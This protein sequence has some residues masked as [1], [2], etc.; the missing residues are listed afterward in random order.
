MQ[1]AQREALA[2]LRLTWAPTADDLWRPQSATHVPGFNE[3]AIEDVIDAVG[4]A[5]RDP[6]SSPLGVVVQGRAGSGKTHLLGQVRER[7]QAS[8]GYFLL[9]ELLDAATFWESV[10]GGIIDSLG[11]PGALRE[12]QLKDLLWELSSIAHVSRADRRAIIGEDD[13]DPGT[14]D[15]F[16]NALAK[17][18]RD[19]V[20]ECHQT[21]R[22]LVLVGATDLAAHDVGEAYLQAS[23]ESGNDERAYWRLRASS[24][25]AQQCV[26]EIS[27]LIALA[28]PTVLALDQIDTLLAQSLARTDDAPHDSG[29]DALHQVADGL[30]AVRQ[31]MRRTVAVVACLPS[32]W[33]G[34][35]TQ[36]TAT[37][38]DRFRVTAPLKPLPTPDIGRAILERRFV[39]SYAETGFQPPYPSWPILPA[40]FIDA[41]DYTPR[42]LLIRAD[43]HV[44]Q[45]LN[46]NEVV[47]LDHLH[48]DA[49]PVW[50]PDGEDAEPVSS[51]ID[52]RFAEYR[53][54]AV[55]AAALDHEGEDTTMPELLSA[56]LTAW[57]AERDADQS[58]N[59]DPPPGRHVALHAR[60]RQSLDR[61]TE[62]ERHWAFRAIAATNA[63]AAQNRI[64]KAWSATGL[65]MGSDRRQ[66]LLLRNS[67]W[68]AG[69][70]TAQLVDDFHRAGGRTVAIS[71][72]DIRTMT[73]I[74]D[75]IGEDP[76][77]LSSWLRVRRPARGLTILREA[78][79]DDGDAPPPVDVTAPEPVPDTAVTEP[80]V[81]DDVSGAALPLGADIRS[82]ATVSVDLAALR[83]HVAIFAG[84]GSGKTVL[85]RRLVEECALR[86]VSSIVLD[87]NNDLARLGTG[88]P[89]RPD[90]WRKSDDRR[91][92]EHL[93]HAEVVIWTPRK[94]AGRPLAF[95]PLPDFPSVVDDEDEFTEAVESAAAALE[96]RASI[97]GQSQKANR[98][99]AVLRNALELYGRKPAP[100]LT[101]FVEMLSDLPDD[102]SDL[103]DAHKIAANLA[104][105][106]RAAMVNDKM[107]GGAGTALD[108]GV[109]LTP[110]PGR[111]ARVSVIS[112]IGLSS[113]EQR[114]SFVN[115]L[116]MALFAWIKR[117]PAGD[118]PLR[119]LL[120][121]DEAQTLAPSRGFTACTRSTLALSSQARKY[122]LGLVFATQAPKGLHNQIP[123]NAVT[124]FYGLLSAPVQITAAQEMARAK[125]GLMPDISRLRAGNF[126][127]AI[128]GEAF[129]RIVAPWCLSYH[130][131]NP[132][133]PEEVVAL[134]KGTP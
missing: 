134:A 51:E 108:P 1:E 130:P 113:D 43:A 97:S 18:H 93:E 116:Q 16:V 81:E 119:G 52:R 53:R 129:R 79:D 24:A 82:G 69:P 19:P 35:R 23:E 29:D 74:R 36:A 57:I 78:L 4:D 58:Y 11:R 7:V 124:Q 100:T 107:F 2:S 42:Q 95:Q 56:A 34:I 98:A 17:A 67:P 121:M 84:T 65:G 62:D 61:A 131:P 86:G 49:Q 25:S 105:D 110:S 120:V 76:A 125:G 104:E 99:R 45:C 14:L 6:V 47:E 128:E 44:R 114:Q 64:K 112:M 5:T 92:A 71:D 13:L 127:V 103:A 132:L 101:G 20:R 80:D 133:S 40:A 12:T 21:L 8:G 89:E 22:A 37:V 126:Y 28:G 111:R 63:V 50:E 48:A 94:A 73:A 60:L 68:P 102:A 41:P 90:G 70:K 15:R 88:W 33:E 10:R 77:E 26:Q 38:V 3:F 66:L 109:L 27:R 30:M 106:L 85:I 123:G 115:Q 54:R 83:K 91:A 122:G 39:A 31:K 75:L 87:P 96:P 59:C 72:D 32:V 9:V 118:R 55:P 117:N 46:H